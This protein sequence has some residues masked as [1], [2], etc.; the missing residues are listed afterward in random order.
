M[1]RRGSL[2]GLAILLWTAPAGADEVYGRVWLTG[3]RAASGATV[4]VKCGGQSR[5]G[6]ADA[7]GSYTVTDTG[8][9]DCVIQVN[10]GPRTVV[11]VSGRTRANLELRDSSLVRR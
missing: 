8:S 7:N 6:V 3:G 4:T 10:N 9:G 1:R 11:T 2:V 5:S